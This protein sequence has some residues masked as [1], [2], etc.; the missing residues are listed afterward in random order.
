[1]CQ[2]IIAIG[3]HFGKKGSKGPKTV[4]LQDMQI[5]KFLSDFDGIFF[6]G[7]LFERAFILIGFPFE[8]AFRCMPSDL[9]QILPFPRY[10][11]L[12]R[13]NVRNCNF[14]ILLRPRKSLCPTNYCIKHISVSSSLMRPHSLENTLVQISVFDMLRSY[15]AALGVALYSHSRR[16]RLER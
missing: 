14:F 16:K 2:K 8:R 15:Y 9:M 1:M 5:L 7:F 3:S 4:F 6:V 10:K 13:T 12:K 11:G